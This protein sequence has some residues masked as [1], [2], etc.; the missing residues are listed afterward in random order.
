MNSYECFYGTDL[1]SEPQA[2][3]LMQEAFTS[4]VLR[5]YGPNLSLSKPKQVASLE[6]RNEAAFWQGEYGRLWVQRIYVFGQPENRRSNRPFWGFFHLHDGKVRRKLEQTY[7]GVVPTV[8]ECYLTLP[9]SLRETGYRVIEGPYTA[10]YGVL[11][12][13]VT[14][15]VFP[16]RLLAGHCAQSA[17]HTALMLM[18]ARGARPLGLFDLNL[19]AAAVDNVT[20]VIVK[21]EGLSLDQIARVLRARE[22]GITA[23]SDVYRAEEWQEEDLASILRDGVLSALPLILAV[24]FETWV[25]S[26]SRH[27]TI[28]LNAVPSG[29]HAVVLVGCRESAQDEAA[30]LFHDSVLGP[31]IQ[32]DIAGLVQATRA[33]ISASVEERSQS[34][35]SAV[36][37]CHM[38]I[39]MPRDVT[40]RLSVVTQAAWHAF[41]AAGCEECRPAHMSRKL[42]SRNEFLHLYAPLLRDAD[43]EFNNHIQAHYPESDLK[44]IWQVRHRESPRITLFYNAGK[45]SRTGSSS[46][47]A[48]LDEDL[49]ALFDPDKDEVLGTWQLR[50]TAPM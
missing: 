37:L 24:D 39:P 48:A 15:L 9:K 26:A 27:Q 46:A 8:A 40:V 16:H 11:P 23:L 25:Q 42:I 6:A 21:N 29:R 18:S 13:D 20:N 14:P 35:E 38:V 2:W 3:D 32:M 34:E 47:F 33:Y 22:T 44:Y 49:F 30:F 45:T 7:G 10:F 50:K 41:V 1:L 17:A 19:L 31:W 43:P 12:L 4:R 28:D 36:P 5:A